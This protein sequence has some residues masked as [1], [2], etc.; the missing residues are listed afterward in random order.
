MIKRTSPPNPLSHWERG[1]K[2]AMMIIV[3]AGAAIFPLA[4]DIELAFKENEE[5]KVIDI[6]KSRD[7]ADDEIAA[8][9]TWIAT[10]KE[11]YRMR[12]TR[13]IR[14]KRTTN[15]IAGAHLQTEIM[16]L[17]KENLVDD[18]LDYTID[19]IS[20]TEYNKNADLIYAV[21]PFLVHPKSK[22]RVVA[23]R[24][25]AEKK[26]ERIYPLIGQLLAGENTIDK[27][28][29][30][31]TLYAL[32]DE[33]AVPLLLLQISNPDKNVRYYAVKTLEAIGSDKAQY[34]IINLA[35]HDVEEEI[36][37]KAIEALRPIKTQPVFYSLQ[38]LIGDSKL[39][40]RSLAL[41]QALAQNDKRYA[42]AISDQLAHETD[43]KQKHELLGALFTLGSGG[44]MNGV[45]A[46]IK[47]ERDSALLLMAALA[48]NRFHD[49]R[50]AE[51]LAELFALTTEESIRIECIVGIAIYKLRKHLMLLTQI[52]EN[53]KLTPLLRSAAL[54]SIQLYDNEAATLALFEIFAHENNQVL[55][56]QMKLLLTD[57]MRRKL[58]KL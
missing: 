28:Y 56:V 14:D 51:L 54:T 58:P 1:S 11:K 31:E 29:A 3:L 47:N 16:R 45:L 27:I 18:D 50:C 38:K 4:P 49:A 26:D 43:T 55:R 7:L 39:A 53:Q 36:R 41:K 2:I 42:Q 37:L 13:A 48:C 5:S 40:V 52:A 24:V 30:M 17:I 9:N 35:E 25:I 15:P 20:A 34:G 57:L 33:R 46:L 32:K 23:N 8:I 10:K 44:G 21:A 6:Y 12:Y 22:L 19:C